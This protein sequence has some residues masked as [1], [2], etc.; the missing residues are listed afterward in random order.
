MELAELK[1][2]IVE[3]YGQWAAALE[4][5]EF[6]DSLTVDPADNDGRMIWY[7]SRRFQF[8][9]P[10]TQCFY[11]AQQMLHLML[12]HTARGAGK[13][14]AVWRRATNAVTTAMLRADGFQPP[15]LTEYVPE[16]ET[17]SAETVYAAL[18]AREPERS[19]DQPMGVE[20][21]PNRKKKQAGD[22]TTARAR[23]ADEPGVA[24]AVTGLAEFLQ[25]SQDVDYDWFP[26]DTIRH[27]LIRDEFRP[28]R[29]ARAEIL[30]DT[31][32][33]VDEALL[34]TFL[35]GVKALLRDAIVRV[36]CFDTRFY[37]FQDVM[38]ESDIENLRLEGAG[39]TNFEI[40]VEAFTGDAENQIIF[41]DGYGE[42][43]TRRCDAVWVVFGTMRV[44]PPG[45]RVIYVDPFGK[46]YKLRDEKDSFAAEKGEWLLT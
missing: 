11:L 9:T 30:I 10:E 3:R 25:P 45:G 23:T 36:G 28:Y 33:S 5:V 38:K 26:G 43:P 35:R 2:M 12:S 29:V 4:T 27:G 39:G 15:T 13:D 22:E 21:R 44:E 41:T 7:N 34:K 1:E 37:G 17:G 18:L 42:M 20:V 8:F 40:A 31:S 16:A 14:P 46:T 32:N 19:A 24:E 6:V